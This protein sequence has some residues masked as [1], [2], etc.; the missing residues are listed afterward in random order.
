MNA[1][2]ILE[3]ITA[4][5]SHQPMTCSQLATELNVTPAEIIGPLR[6]ALKGDRFNERNGFYSVLPL[7]VAPNIPSIVPCA[8]ATTAL[9]AGFTGQILA[10]LEQRD[11]TSKE[12]SVFT[13]IGS[14]RISAFLRYRVVQGEV[15]KVSKDG[16][17]YYHLEQRPVRMS[18]KAYPWVEGQ[19]IPSWVRALA[20]GVR[21]CESV[22]IV[23]ELDV[24]KQSQG[25]PQFIA[26]YI[27]M[28]LNRYICGNTAENVSDHVLRY[29]PFDHS[30]VETDHAE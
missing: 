21:G 3:K 27:D 19:V 23:A 28:R 9:P 5:L 13:G 17:T 8:V 25:W 6:Q 7:T 20:T 11:M 22:Y 24:G 26:A 16:Q 29:L 18:R 1:D 10:A 4:L 15:S 30:E 12:L 14:S 2:V